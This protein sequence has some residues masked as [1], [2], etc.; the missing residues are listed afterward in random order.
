MESPSSDSS[1]ASDNDVDLRLTTGLPEVTA[2][3][4][5]RFGLGSVDATWDELK[6]SMS[7]IMFGG[8]FSSR[9]R[10]SSI[11]GTTKIRPF[12]VT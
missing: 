4:E 5:S 1:K 12:V 8:T 2:V 11:P 6:G 3:V 9:R 10:N 7:L